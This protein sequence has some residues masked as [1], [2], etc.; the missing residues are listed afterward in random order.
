MH[1]Q[2]RLLRCLLVV[3]LFTLVLGCGFLY[4]VSLD[5]ARNWPSL[6]Y[7]RVPIYVATLVGCIPVVVI[8]KFGFDILS[9]VDRGEIFS[10]YTIQ[11]LS[12][13][14]RLF[15]GILASYFTIGLVVFWIMTGLMHPT[16][17][18]AWFVMALAALLMFTGLALFERIF[19]TTLQMI[20]KYDLTV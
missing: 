6:A 9:V 20:R 8:I 18:F 11:R 2:T 7:L 1:H 13:R 10:D 17:V 16:L 14:I 19:T 15:I 5:S 3:C 4:L 12:R